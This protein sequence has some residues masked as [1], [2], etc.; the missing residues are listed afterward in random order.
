MAGS[1]SQ[2]RQYRFILNISRSQ[3]EEV[4]QI[5]A[6]LKAK[7]AFTRAVRIGLLL[8]WSLSQGRID[9]LLAEFPWIAEQLKPPSPPLYA[10]DELHEQL[11]RIEAKMSEVP[12]QTNVPMSDGAHP[13]LNQGSNRP[14]RKSLSDEAM[15]DLLEVQVAKPTLL[16]GRAWNIAHC[17]IQVGLYHLGSIKNL[18]DL[19][20]EVLEY[21]IQMG[22]LPAAQ[23][24][25][26][27]DS[28][29]RRASKIPIIEAHIKEKPTGNARPLAGSEVQFSAPVVT[30]E[31]D[32]FLN[33]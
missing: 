6:S 31:L 17:N 20:D 8:F 19:D 12:L 1:Y 33:L 28:R 27:L 30:D 13:L 22:K 4:S 7:R 15:G 9:V 21:G 18:G 5:I 24:A 11:R 26:V 23:A 32:D 29:R 25:E 3:D 2:Q 14:E 10:L 16:Q